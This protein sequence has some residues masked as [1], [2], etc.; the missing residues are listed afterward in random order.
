MPK[1]SRIRFLNLALCLLYSLFYISSSSPTFADTK[2]S[3]QAEAAILIDAK[4]G[5]ILYE[6]NA[7]KQY[8]PASITKL[9]TALLAIE[10]L[11]PNDIITFSQEAV[12][13]IEYNSSHI[14]MDIGEQITVDQALHG[15][16]L[17]SANEVANGLAE[18]ISG[19]IDNFAIAMTKRAY[20]IGATST[21]FMNPHG[22][23][24]S[25]HYTTAYDMALIMRELYDNE[26]F[27]QIMATPTYQILPTNKTDVIVYLSQQHS[28]MNVVRDSQMYRADVIGG[29]TGYTS[30]AGNTLVTAASKNGVDLI[31]VILKGTNP[32]YYSDTNK[33][34]DYGFNTFKSL[35]LASST[36]TLTVLPLY[37]VQSGQLFEVAS[38]RVRVSEDVTAIVSSSVN[39]RDLEVIIDLPEHLTLGAVVGDIIGEISYYYQNKKIA[40][41]ELIIST[42]DFLPAPT[43]ADFPANSSIMIS[44]SYI[45]PR[46]TGIV[47][48]FFLLVLILKTRQKNMFYNRNKTLKFTKTLK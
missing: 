2:P 43:S 7:Y 44:L 29:K 21:N 22:L 4:T 14:G 25:D 30:Q 32:T 20:D 9:M 23:H 13:S 12:F 48:G 24:D 41:S 3:I 17:N 34:L 16:L 19:S 36:N 42:I 38:S 46:I 8:Y 31:C 5:T 37:S 15:L 11:S 40:S 18:K 26:Y 1:N 27:L 6:K 10:N 28:L 35:D 47:A 33:L 45:L 39:E